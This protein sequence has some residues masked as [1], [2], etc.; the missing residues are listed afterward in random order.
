MSKKEYIELKKKIAKEERAKLFKAII[1][2]ILV[3]VLINCLSASNAS[4]M[5]DDIL[6]NELKTENGLGT[7]EAWMKYQEI[8]K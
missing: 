6:K 1:L 3:I 4:V 5:D 7:K 2:I 8:Q